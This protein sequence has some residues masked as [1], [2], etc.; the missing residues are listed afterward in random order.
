M[1]TVCQ[2][3]VHLPGRAMSV[4]NKHL[5]VAA[6]TASQSCVEIIQIVHVV[7]LPPMSS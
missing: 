3:C 1:P 5:L 2:T 6:S 4:F 7:P